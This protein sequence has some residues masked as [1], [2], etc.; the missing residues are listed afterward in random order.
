LQNRTG[1]M[2]GTARA[3]LFWLGLVLALAGIQFFPAAAQPSGVEA[4]P[5]LDEIVQRLVAWNEQRARELGPYTSRRHYHVEYHGF[6]HAAVADMVVDASY[7][8][9]SSRHFTVVSQSGSH[10]L[11]EHVLG[12]LLRTE[13]ESTHDRA[14]NALSPANYNFTLGRT[15]TVG[16]RL[17]YVLGVEPKKPRGLLYRGTIWVDA[18]DYAVVKI[19]A[20]PAKNP[21]F[22]ISDTEIHHVYEKDGDFWLPKS[23]RSETKVRLGGT[24][25]LTI[26][27]GDYRFA[28]KGASPPV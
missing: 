7:D 8:G 2:V 28:A 27:Y 3:G 4:G 14:D 13:Q 6:P 9:P 11:L 10:L 16:G 5:S 19:D 26:E 1:E 18:Q 21:S 20:H 22:W 12:K 15:E 24:A 17:A 25:I 23:N